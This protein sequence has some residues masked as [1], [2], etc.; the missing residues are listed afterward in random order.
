MRVPRRVS[1]SGF[2]VGVLPRRACK[3]ETWARRHSALPSCKTILAPDRELAKA[4]S[5]RGWLS[6]GWR[7]GGGD[8]RLEQG[9]GRGSQEGEGGNGRS[10]LGDGRAVKA[11]R[12]VS[13]VRESE[14]ERARGRA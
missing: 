5:A 9:P 10:R 6:W 12:G 14:R 1:T 3:A 7:W 8:G 4:R 13:C 11:H 2:N